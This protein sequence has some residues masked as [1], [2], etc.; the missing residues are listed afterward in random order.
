ME[1]QALLRWY[2]SKVKEAMHKKE[3]PVTQED[4]YSLLWNFS[5]IDNF[6]QY[7]KVAIRLLYSNFGA[8]DGHFS[9]GKL[10]IE[11]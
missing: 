8:N 1:K 11:F 10:F 6:F 5:K 4:N 9:L 7:E 3:W 2:K